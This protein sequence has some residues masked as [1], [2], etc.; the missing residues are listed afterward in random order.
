MIFQGKLT[1]RFFD[2][3]SSSAFIDTENGVIVLGH[4]WSFVNRDNGKINIVIVR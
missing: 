4:G 1:V 3:F 2:V